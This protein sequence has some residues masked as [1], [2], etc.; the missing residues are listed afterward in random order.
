MLVLTQSDVRALVSMREAIEIVTAAVVENA[1]GRADV[2]TRTYLRVPERD[3][4]CLFM[5][6][7]LPALG[8][9]GQKIIVEFPRNAEQG[10]PAVS[11]IFTLLDEQ[12]GLAV[13]VMDAGYLT[14]LRTAAVIGVGLR[15]LAPSGPRAAALLGTGGQARGQL[16]A[17][18]EVL[19]SLEEV[20]LWGRRRPTAE[21]LAGEAPELGVGLPLHVVETA[22]EAVQGADVVIAATAAREPVVRDAWVAP[23]ALVCALGAYTPDAHEVDSATVGRAAKVVADS[24]ASA[25]ASSGELLIPIGEG[26]LSAERVADLGSIVAGEQP[27]RES[28]DELIFFKSAGFAVLDLAVGKAV[29]DRAAAAGRGLQ[30]DLLG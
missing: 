30:V 12:T 7:Y 15:H 1:A 11:G 13:A 28:D 18:G 29:A 22:E 19:P 20:R 10:L 14:V 23:G 17:L 3:A 21:A 6:G 9:L 24:R 25:L 2:P 16:Q 26:L 27:G 5:P 8:S 4:G